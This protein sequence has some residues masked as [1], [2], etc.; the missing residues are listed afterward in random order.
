[1]WRRITEHKAAFVEPKKKD[2]FQ[3]A[4]DDFYTKVADPSLNGA[5]FMAVCRG[6]VSEGLDFADINGRAVVIT[7]LPF[8]PSRDP[9]VMLK[10]EFLKLKNSKQGLKQVLSGRE[11]YQQQAHRAVNQAIGRVIRHKD[12][13]GAI[14]LCDIRF[15]YDSNICHLPQWLRSH[16]K[17]FEK[18]G[19]ALHHLISFFKTAKN[20][21]PQPQACSIK[22][23]RIP[24]ATASKPSHGSY[25]ESGDVKRRLPSARASDVAQHV[26]SLGQED[27]SCEALLQRYSQTSASHTPSTRP[28][29]LQMLTDTDRRNED[30]TE[31]RPMPPLTTT[32]TTNGDPH[33]PHQPPKKSSRKRVVIVK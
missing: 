19:Q 23:K 4:I 26:P 20:M 17:K 8:P 16:V 11:W 31:I 2:D 28:G 29:L 13:Y 22:G 25:F 3:A 15:T 14:I 10:M 6:K 32:S 9:R 24:A 30:F 27:T 18:Y 21:L 1:I 5:I 7:G 12:D 33:H